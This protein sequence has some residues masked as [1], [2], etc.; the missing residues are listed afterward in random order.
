MSSPIIFSYR[1][2]SLGKASEESNLKK[3]SEGL[4][5]T[6]LDA[7]HENIKN[8]IKKFSDLDPIIVDALIAAETRPRMLQSHEGLLLILRGVNLNEDSRP[9]DMVSIRLWIDNQQII[10]LRKFKLKAVQD[11][12][13]K[14]KLGNG[15]RDSGSFI[16]MLI[17]MLF[18][19]MQPVISELDEM[20]DEIEENLLESPDKIYAIRL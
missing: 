10:S 9:E 18:E 11:I 13:S 1:L 16:C 19:R 3:N 4:L 12:E 2:D 6:H 15:P 17:S 7:N 14:L 5:W 20:T 8:S